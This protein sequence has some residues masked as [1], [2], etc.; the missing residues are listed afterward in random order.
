V[1]KVRRIGSNLDLL[2]HTAHVRVLV[3]HRILDGHNVTRIALVDLIDQRRER[4]RFPSASRATDEHQPS[5]EPNQM[6]DLNRKSQLAEQGHLHRKRA[7]RR[8]GAIL[9]RPNRRQHRLDQRFDF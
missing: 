4:R 2:D 3:F 1:G 6:A 9:S 5:T 8:R 7:D